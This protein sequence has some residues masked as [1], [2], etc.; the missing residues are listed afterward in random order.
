M[1]I[2]L[3]IMA[4]L[5]LCAAPGRA[6]FQGMIRM[7]A[8]SNPEDDSSVV[9]STVYFRGKLLAA[10]IEPDTADG[11]QGAKFIIRGD[12]NLMWVVLDTDRKIIEIP[13]GG[14][15][16]EASSGKATAPVGYTLE[17]TG[18]QRKLAGYTCEG[19]KA[20]EGEGKTA[21]IWA[22]RA[23]G[24][25]YDG[26]VSWFDEMS[27]E[28]ATSGRRWE[29]ELADSGLFPLRIVRFDEGEATESEE[30]VGVEE[31][32]VPDSMFE[33]PEGYRRE[34]VNMN[35][36]KMFEEMMKNMQTDSTGVGEDDEPEDDPG[37]GAVTPGT[38]VLPD[39]SGRGTG[40]VGNTVI[41]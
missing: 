16:K 8:V 37:G 33:A 13:I 40:A 11:E 1:K 17:P 20:D 34:R 18:E 22:T 30:V 36:D 14:R 4:A 31:T 38:S 29:R 32:E 7:V 39:S 10:V 41:R 27:L 12:R 28:S 25:L 3:P 9:R 6:Q 26:V 2:F 23:L 35:F 5:L 21:T 24:N 19:W 15:H